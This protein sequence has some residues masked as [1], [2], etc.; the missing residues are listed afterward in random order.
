MSLL[1][2]KQIFIILIMCLCGLVAGLVIDVFRLFERRFFS[3]IKFVQIIVG[4]LGS[5]V[6]AYLIGEF[7]YYCQNGKISVVGGIAFFVGLLL[8]YKYFCDIISVGE[9]NEQKGKKAP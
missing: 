6:V 5:V 2:Q 8:W 9:E 1:I 3:K 4:L 7:S